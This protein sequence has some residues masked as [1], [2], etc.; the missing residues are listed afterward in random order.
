MSVRQ[1][2]GRLSPFYHKQLSLGARF[3]VEETGWLRAEQF[4]NPTEEKEA[5]ERSVGLAD[6]SHLAKLNLNQRHV[7]EFVEELYGSNGDIRGRVLAGGPGPL[8]DAWCMVLAK[9]EAMLVCIESAKEHVIKHLNASQASHIMIVDVSSV[10][11]GCYFIG[12]NSRRLL[13]KLTELNVNAEE[14]HNLTVTHTPIRHVPTILLRTDVG[15]LL[16]YQLYFERAYAEFLW[17]AIFT[18]GKELDATPVGSS[19]MKLLGLNSG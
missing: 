8:S 12:P 17:D 14:F 6:L 9:D 1:T 5:T 11:A 7:A 16:A 15:S 2:G 4:T 13:R 19:A 10:F 18:A 3:T